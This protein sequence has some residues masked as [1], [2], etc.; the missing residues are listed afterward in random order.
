VEDRIQ[1]GRDGRTQAII[2]LNI[3]ST[4]NIPETMKTMGSPKL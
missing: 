3:D 4:Q 1:E 2:H